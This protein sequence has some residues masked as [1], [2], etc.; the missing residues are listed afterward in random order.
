LHT[1]LL[2]LSA[3]QNSSKESF[4]EAIQSLSEAH[5]K[6]SRL[7]RDMPTQVAPELIRLGLPGALQ[8]LVETDLRDSF[9]EVSV[10]IDPAVEEPV[11]RLPPHVS[12]VIFY[13][14]REAIRN[15]ARH[16]RGLAS[17]TYEAAE[18]KPADTANAEEPPLL[19]LDLKMRWRVGGH[20]PGLELTITDTGVGLVHGGSTINLS[21]GSGQGLALH[22]TLLAVIGGS[23]ELS[24]AAGKPTTVTIFFPETGVPE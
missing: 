2:S 5:V 16:G 17:S 13:A 18:T 10:D 15:A 7:L 21:G 23:L 8:Q 22:S 4:A 14:A 1:T 12:E 3:S 9:D 20:Q 24:S 6:I 11:S 19:R